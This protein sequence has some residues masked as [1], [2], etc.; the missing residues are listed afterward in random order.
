M[1][2][3]DKVL[4]I[5]SNGPNKFFGGGQRNLLFIK[6]LEAKGFQVDLALLLNEKWEIKE[7]SEIVEKWRSSFNLVVSFQIKPGKPFTP[8][9]GVLHWILRNS[10]KYK[11]IYYRDEPIA[12]KA[13]FFCFK[14]SKN[15]IDYNDF[16]LPNSNNLQKLKYVPLYLIEKLRIKN[17]ICMDKRHMLYFKSKALFIPNYPLPLFESETEK[18]FIKKKSIFPSI[19]FVGSYL[20]YLIDFID[21]ASF[22]SLLEIDNLKIFI[23]SGSITFELIE[24]FKHPAFIWLDNVKDLV[25]FYSQ[26]WI[27]I[28]PG[29]KK[30]GPLIKLIESIYY[31]TPVIC[32][33]DALLGYEFFNAE[34]DLIPAS[35]IK[36]EMVKNI[37]NYLS[38]PDHIDEV[39][40]KLYAIME[41]Q[42]SFQGVVDSL[43]T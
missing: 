27:S 35:N 42:F 41:K 37:S 38:N 5:A 8:S 24:K 16:I 17:A 36:S 32:S 1:N 26:A 43:P 6:A 3:K 22:K 19:L 30:D 10:L 18:V 9:F 29:Y 31:R 13:G 28:V 12:W 14:R 34:E 23:I 7:G 25:P 15:I 39:S 11:Y 2:L 40:S 4:I 33:C 21:D 20:N